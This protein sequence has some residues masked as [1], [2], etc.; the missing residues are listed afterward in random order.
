MIKHTNLRDRGS[1]QKNLGEYE[2]TAAKALE[3]MVVSELGFGGQVIDLSPTRVAIET[4]LFGGDIDTTIFE[5][6]EEEMVL[7]VKVAAHHAMIMNDEKSRE[8][9]IGKA[10]D[11]LGMLPKEIGGLPLYIS[12]LAPFLLGG[13][14]AGVAL[15]FGV[16]ITDP[17]IVKTFAPISLKDLVAAVGLSV[18]TGMPLPEVVQE[19]KLATA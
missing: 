8:V 12:L 13:R 11:S 2:Q 19:M 1:G 3:S 7:I 6:S 4:P 15:L 5:G 9:I 10:V 14:S 18:E 17:E 16:G